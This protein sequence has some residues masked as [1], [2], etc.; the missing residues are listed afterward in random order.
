MEFPDLGPRGVAACGYQRRLVVWRLSNHLPF[1]LM[2]NVPH[3]PAQLALKAEIEAGGLFVGIISAALVGGL[4][5]L[6]LRGSYPVLAWL[7]A[8]VAFPLAYAT[9]SW[10]Y[11]SVKSSAATCAACGAQFGITHV[12][13]DESLISAL[14][15]KRQSEVG[16]MVSGPN[17]GKRIVRIESW[18]EER[19]RI[20]DT[21]ACSVCNQVSRVE[22]TETRD[23]GKVSDDVYRR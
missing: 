6:M 22:S 13:R 1:R 12:G 23:A 18:T 15:R 19:Y 10:V 5:W 4:V 14:P 16:R 7:C 9:G 8:A 11:K 21:Y 17:E 2:D 20:V 3:S